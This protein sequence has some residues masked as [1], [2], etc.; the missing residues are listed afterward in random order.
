[1]I[2]RRRF[3]TAV[4]MAFAFLSAATA[5]RTGF[6]VPTTVSQR[7]KKPE[8]DKIPDPGKDPIWEL[9]RPPK[10]GN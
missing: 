9:P 8:K 7:P 6:G 1:M 2:N 10:K 5:N 4:P 3:F